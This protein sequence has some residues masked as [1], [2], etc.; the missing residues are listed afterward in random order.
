MRS[1]AWTFGLW[2]SD[3]R[4]MCRWSAMSAASAVS[5]V[6]RVPGLIVVSASLATLDRRPLKRRAPSPNVERQVCGGI[7]DGA[8]LH[9]RMRACS[10]HRA[11]LL[12][13]LRMRDMRP[14]ATPG[15]SSSAPRPRNWSSHTNSRSATSKTSRRSSSSR[16]V[17]RLSASWETDLMRLTMRRVSSTHIARALFSP[18]SHPMVINGCSIVVPCSKSPDQPTRCR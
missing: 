17:F 7:R 10:S 8:V 2:P 1:A 12:A 14:E 3:A 16:A 18:G 6:H 11:A 5:S 4:A 13:V 9:P 15:S